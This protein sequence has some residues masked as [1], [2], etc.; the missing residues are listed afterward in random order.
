MNIKFDQPD[1]LNTKHMVRLLTSHNLIQHILEPTHNL[2]HTLD[3]VI[4]RLPSLIG[5]IDISPPGHSDHSI[6]HF[7]ITTQPPPRIYQKIER[8]SFSNFDIF[9]FQKDL[10]ETELYRMTLQPTPPVTAEYLFTLYDHTME[11][12]LNTHAPLHKIT[13]R[14]KTDCPW[15]DSECATLKRK[16]RHIERKC[17]HS[18]KDTRLINLLKLQSQ[19]QRKIFQHKRSV[20]LRQNIEEAEKDGKA[21]WKSLNSI[22]SPQ[23]PTE[24]PLTPDELLDNFVNKTAAIRHSTKD[25][26][27]PVLNSNHLNFPGL[28]AFDEL[29][30]PEVD[31]LLSDSSSKHCELD[32]SPVWIIKSLRHIF[33][34]ILLLL[35]NCSLN[36]ATLPTSHK[37][38]II[39]PRLKKSGLDPSDPSNYRP[40][41]NLSFISKLVERAVH[42]QL[43]NYV[44]SNSLLPLAQSGFRRLHST[45]TAVLKVYNEIIMALDSGFITALLLLDFSSAFDCVDH[46]ILLQVLES[47]FGIMASA[48]L[49]IANF[50]TN[51]SHSV[52]L[53]SNTSRYFSILFGV[54]QGSILGPLLFILYTSNIVHIAF[55]H[56]IFI[57]LYADDTQLYIKLSTND[58]DNAM[59]RLINCFTEIQSWCAS[60]RLKLNASKTEL[61]FFY[62]HLLPNSLDTVLNLGPDCSIKPADVVRDLG[63]LL[64]NS[65]SMKNQIS[66]ITKSCFFHL[67]RIRQ[68]KKSLNEKCL[69][70]LVQALVISR[71]DYC[72]S[73]LY[74]L[75]ASTLQPLTT[76]LHCA[77]KLIKNLNA[78]DHITPT[79][80]EL[81][82]L[83]IQARINFKICLLMY[84]IYTHTSPSYLSSLVTL[85]SSIQ[86]RR[87]LRSSSQGD[88]VVTR[89]L[90][91]LGNRAFALAGPAEWNKLPDFIRK[92]STLSIFKTNLKTYLFKIYYD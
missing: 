5:N 24:C 63:V 53:G 49:W 56:G 34:P 72:N 10:E 32:S 82:W 3:V 11:D 39:R 68:V 46:S 18:P 66:S 27:L 91:K 89:S 12:L 51:R 57:H 22:L 6:I 48:L 35:I 7:T 79:L 65:L 14:K 2:G 31:K 59:F 26:P 42:C 20:Y 60:M 83:P 70:T 36:T 73:V 15:F 85:C 21:L 52:R 29:S 81:H 41:S 38:A 40:I 76:V 47:Q 16:T 71:I 28:C 78:R 54:P 45:E 55:K 50:L 1:N 90:K 80:R 19:K 4:S 43:L 75:P 61:I 9:S 88:F 74:G 8:R 30:L 37:R 17:K 69:R 58:F 62:R 44:E 64:D 25:A 23:S 67:R 84:R 92:S 77:A 86:S 33:V 13:I 87:G